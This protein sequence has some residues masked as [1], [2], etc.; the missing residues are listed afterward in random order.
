MQDFIYPVSEKKEFSRAMAEGKQLV[1]QGRLILELNIRIHTNQWLLSGHG[2][3]N[4][5]KS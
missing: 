4:R 1:G 2:A 5:R 3:G